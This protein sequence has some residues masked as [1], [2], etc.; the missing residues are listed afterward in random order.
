MACFRRISGRFGGVA[1][2]PGGLCRNQFWVPY[3]DRRVLMCLGIHGQLI[4]IDFER[5][6]VVVKLSSWPRPL[7][8]ALDAATLALAD[9]AAAA[10]TS[11][12]VGR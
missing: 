2:L 7:D 6:V 1:G 4:Y 10:A 5:A 8:P 11:R 3:P 9:A 12:G